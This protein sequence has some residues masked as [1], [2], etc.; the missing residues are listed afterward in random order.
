MGGLSSVP[1]ARPAN[2]SIRYEFQR[3]SMLGRPPKLVS[4]RS[5]GPGGP[6]AEPEAQR[7]NQIQL[8]NH[9][10]R[11]HWVYGMTSAVWIG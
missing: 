1:D 7:G 3:A 10:R 2:E 9:I 6:E 5:Y 4:K 11:Y 8:G